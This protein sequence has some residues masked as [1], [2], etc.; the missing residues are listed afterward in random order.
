MDKNLEYYQLSINQ[1][2]DNLKTTTDGLSQKEASQRLAIYGKNTLKEIHKTSKI[3]K[4]LAQF[5]DIL[6]ILLIVSMIISIYLE[7]VR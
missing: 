3:I 1:T 6:I 5:K 4:F 2:L 7:D